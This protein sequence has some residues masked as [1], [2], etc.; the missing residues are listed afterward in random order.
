MT[1]IAVTQLNTSLDD[2]EFFVV[3]DATDDDILIAAGVERAATV[4]VAKHPIEGALQG[5][6]GQD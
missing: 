5:D 3:G 1:V 2:V 6:I 4:V